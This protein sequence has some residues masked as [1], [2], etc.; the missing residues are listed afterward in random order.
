MDFFVPPL[1]VTGLAVDV[2]TFKYR[3]R[4]PDDTAAFVAGDVPFPVAFFREGGCIVAD[5]IVQPDPFPAVGSG[6]GVGFITGF[7]EHFFVKGD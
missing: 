4:C 3:F 5:G 6:G 1:F 7:T 2:I